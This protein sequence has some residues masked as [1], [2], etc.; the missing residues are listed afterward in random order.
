MH[1]SITV[2]TLTAQLIKFRFYMNESRKIRL[3][4]LLEHMVPIPKDVFFKK[5]HLKKD[6]KKRH[7]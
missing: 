1:V 7:P 4:K 5:L 2:K 6:N 3:H